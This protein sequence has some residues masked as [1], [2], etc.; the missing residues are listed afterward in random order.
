MDVM[1]L[2]SFPCFLLSCCTGTRDR[3]GEGWS[4]T[5]GP[6]SPNTQRRGSLYTN[7]PL[8]G[9]PLTFLTA[10]D[11]SCSGVARS[12]AVCVLER[13]TGALAAQTRGSGRVGGGACYCGYHTVSAEWA[14][15]WRKGREKRTQPLTWPHRKWPLLWRGKWRCSVILMMVSMW[16]VASAC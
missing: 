5:A 6:L 11:W 8:V 13:V 3:R 16:C 1:I 9:F 14:T 4:I 12:L 10:A 7:T 2:C 15:G